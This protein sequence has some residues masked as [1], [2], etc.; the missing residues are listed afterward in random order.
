MAEPQA[1]RSLLLA[2]LALCVPLFFEAQALAADT[3][4]ILSSPVPTRAEDSLVLPDIPNL[5]PRPRA[6]VLQIPDGDTLRLT[7]RRVIRLACVDAPDLALS[8]PT[9]FAN[10][11]LREENFRVEGE[12]R[13]AAG[14]ADKKALR[15]KDARRHVNQYFA[16]EARDALRKLALKRHVTLRAK[17]RKKDPQGRLVAD[18]VLENGTSLAAFLVENG[19]AYVVHDPD[20][21]KGY[22]EALYALQ[23]RAMQARRGFWGKILE[24]EA[25]R[26]PWTGNTETRLFYSGNDVRSQQIK[27][28]LRMYFGTLLDAFSSG[29]APANSRDFWPPTGKNAG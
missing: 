7:D 26:L 28:R 25:A 9:H 8:Q 16:L 21:P 14:D 6:I 5:E 15:R 27:P 1:G 18:V 3:N 11:E 19:F 12:N 4:A 22:L 2:S 20:F 23:H 29:Y 24:I 17:I 10:Q 13:K